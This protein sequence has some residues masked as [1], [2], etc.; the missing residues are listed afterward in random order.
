MQSPLEVQREVYG[1]KGGP[2]LL[3]ATNDARIRKRR[4]LSHTKQTMSSEQLIAFAQT[5]NRMETKAISTCALPGDFPPELSFRALAAYSLLRTLSL[6]LRLSPFTPNVFLRALYLP[7]PNKLMGQVHVSLLRILLLNLNMGYSFKGK[8]TIIQ[9]HKK[10]QIDNIRLSSRAGDNLTLLDGLSWPLF[11]DDYAHLTADRLWASIHNED[12]Y[13]DSRYIGLQ[14]MEVPEYQERPETFH[15]TTKPSTIYPTPSHNE[16]NNTTGVSDDSMHPER[17]KENSIHFQT[18]KRP[19]DFVSPS[20]LTLHTQSRTIDGTRPLV[21]PDHVAEEI[22]NFVSNEM[23]ASANIDEI[24][25]E[26]SGSDKEEEYP[27]HKHFPHFEPLK[28][29]RSG[30]PYH[31]LSIAQ[32][33][34]ILEFLIDELLNVDSIAAEFTRRREALYYQPFTYGALPTETEF[35]YLNNADEC[36]VCR[37][38]G[39]L[40]CCDGCPSSYHRHCLDMSEFQALPEGTWLCPECRIAD[41]SS[42]G[43]LKSGAKASIDWF[44]AEEIA[45]VLKFQSYCQQQ[46]NA[47]SININHGLT[48]AANFD[49]GAGSVKSAPIINKTLVSSEMSLPTS[50]QTFTPTG[51]TSLHHSESDKRIIKDVLETCISAVIA[52]NTYGIVTSKVPLTIPKD[53]DLSEFEFLVVHGFVFCRKR[54]ITSTTAYMILPREEVERHL[55]RFGLS[56]SKA[57]PFVQI[58]AEGALFN[59]KF[60]MSASYFTDPETFNPSFYMNKYSRAPLASFTTKAIETTTTPKLLLQSYES[61]C[62]SSSCDRLSDALMKNMAFDK[63]LSDI[64]KSDVSL[65]DPYSFVKKYMLRLEGTLRKAMLLDGFWESGRNQSRHELWAMRVQKCKSVQKLAILLLK[66]VDSINARAFLD[67][68]FH[69]S[70]LRSGHSQIVSERNYK[71]LPVA[72]NAKMEI[73]KRRWERTP[74]HMLLSLCEREKCDLASFVT[75]IRSDFGFQTS[76]IRSKR[77]KRRVGDRSLVVE[78]KEESYPLWSD[79]SVVKIQDI[80]FP[81]EL[82]IPDPPQKPYPAYFQFANSKRQEV[83]NANP[84][85]DQ[86]ELSKKLSSMWKDSTNEFRAS[87]VQ[88]EM[89][90]REAYKIEIEEYR[91]AKFKMEEMRAQWYEDQIKEKVKE[92]EI[93][94]IVSNSKFTTTTET[95][96]SGLRADADEENGMSK[97][98]KLEIKPSHVPNL[99]DPERVD[100]PIVKDSTES[101]VEPEYKGVVQDEKSGE[102]KGQNESSITPQVPEIRK[103]S[104]TDKPSSDSKSSS[105][106]EDNEKSTNKPQKKRKR[107]TLSANQRT[108]RSGRLARTSTSMGMGSQAKP[109]SMIVAEVASTA[110][111]PRADNPRL[112]IEAYKRQH[113]KAMEKLIKGAPTSGGFW[114]LAGR[115]P[116]ATVG[117][118]PPS[119]MRRLA[120]NSGCVQAPHVAYNTNHEVGQVCWYH[121][122][123]K[124]TEECFAFED[125]IY[126]IRV[127]ESFLDRQSIHSFEG[128]ARRGKTQIQKIVKCSLKDPE[129]GLPHHF[130]VNKKSGKGCWIPE[131]SMD[132]STLVLELDTR[133]KQHVSIRHARLQEI[134]KEMAAE[135]KKKADKEAQ[136][137]Q[138]AA[139]FEQKKR[140]EMKKR[141]EEAGRAAMILAQRRREEDRVATKLASNVMENEASARRSESE[142]IQK[143]LNKLSAKKNAGMM[144]TADDYNLQIELL[145]SKH[146]INFLQ[147]V[148]INKKGGVPISEAPLEKIR[149]RILPELNAAAEGL[150]E[151]DPNSFIDEQGLKELMQAREKSAIAK[152]ASR[153]TQN[154]GFAGPKPSNASPPSHVVQHMVP[155]ANT[156]MGYGP[157]PLSVPSR[158]TTHPM[159][160]TMKQMQHSATGFYPNPNKIQQ[161]K[162]DARGGLLTTSSTIIGKSISLESKPQHV[163]E[164]LNNFVT[165]QNQSKL[166]QSSQVM[167]PQTKSS[168]ESRHIGSFEQQ[169]RKERMMKAMN[170]KQQI[171]P[172]QHAAIQQQHQQNPQMILPHLQQDQTRRLNQYQQ[173]QQQQVLLPFPIPFLQHPNA[174]F[175]FQVQQGNPTIMQRNMMHQNKH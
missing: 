175:P 141:M 22:R 116:F 81:E 139:A 119:E 56:I 156:I 164:L 23:D 75:G 63:L 117:N 77:K 140:M 49:F 46:S 135:E 17:K 132:I 58:P 18:L 115:I 13:I 41:P 143:K 3:E 26:D 62:G 157:Y 9:V 153:K 70:A 37:L 34:D 92:P 101:M 67:G 166:T 112:E 51:Q 96:K 103:G 30:T 128:T 20:S 107:Y 78:M 65:F 19:F 61:V 14:T 155:T 50:V 149:G 105:I 109:S 120:R 97:N 94:E 174:A 122:W 93:T 38:E 59:G 90:Q 162:T 74:S 114:P 88:E 55:K 25:V 10:R 43:P 39:D 84:H 123:R 118:L 4:K 150:E 60:P 52:R 76:V 110:Y 127:L 29:M 28:R 113:I 80:T 8:G 57:W 40:L 161:D 142:S 64:L 163:T 159:N 85:L 27:A 99:T 12:D 102:K 130:V 173:Q 6:Q 1:E 42:F 146:E 15:G 147:L 100:I 33:I 44:E 133:R 32:K 129:S 151:C 111:F 47:P 154:L 170:A 66:L 2:P 79:A 95:L 108:R 152:V 169:L 121:V 136:R 148:D 104:P 106:D 31:R 5:R 172:S 138:A 144:L 145:L 91:K 73:R 137:L 125:L 35:E 165:A 68:W 98:E 83:K 168:Q 89:R 16:K 160:T 158:T 24:T 21:V 134:A 131:A 36:A 72:W 54:S 53:V 69:N 11:C 87:Y 86:G 48:N 167:M 126:Q 124:R 7:Y 45:N 82:K 171:L 71:E